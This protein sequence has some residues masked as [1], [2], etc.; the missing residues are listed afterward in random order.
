MVT[1]VLAAIAAL[2][3]AVFLSGLWGAAADGMRAAEQAA[4]L[5]DAL[6]SWMLRSG[7]DDLSPTQFLAASALVGAA[8]GVVGT[9]LAGPGVIAL[10]VATTSS[11]A[12]TLYWRRRHGRASSRR[13]GSACPRWGVPYPRR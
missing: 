6:R 7:L 11:L 9:F 3:M 4:A 12:P 2:G 5:P 1:L 10:S 8:A 13:Y